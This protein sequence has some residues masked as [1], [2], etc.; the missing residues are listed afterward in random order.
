V[1][2][3]RIKF[4]RNPSGT[5]LVEGQL[6]GGVPKK[7][8][9]EAVLPELTDLLNERVRTVPAD[10]DRILQLFDQGMCQNRD[11]SMA[12]AGDE[13]I[14]LCEVETNALVQAI[15]TPDVQLFDAMGNYA[16][17]PDNVEA[18]SI[19][20]GIGFTAVAAMFTPPQ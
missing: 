14:D 1:T 16:P 2:A 20:V 7:Q 11:G 15:L 10:R 5:N 18:D 3:G 19:S 13:K 12:I 6:N 9:D 17:N 8:F 4:R